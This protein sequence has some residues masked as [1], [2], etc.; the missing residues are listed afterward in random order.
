MYIHTYIRVAFIYA[1][2]SFVRCMSPKLRR[3][4]TAIYV[5][6]VIKTGHMEGLLPPITQIN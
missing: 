1:G 2:A 6:I 5:S 3:S 4:K